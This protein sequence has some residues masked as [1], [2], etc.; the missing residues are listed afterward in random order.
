MP[1]ETSLRAEPTATE[2]WAAFVATLRPMC[3][4]YRLIVYRQP[5]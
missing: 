5:R 1:F 3:R 2:R 4:P